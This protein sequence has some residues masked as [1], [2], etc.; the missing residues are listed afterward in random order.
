[1]NELEN[2]YLKQHEPIRSCYLALRE[3]ILA[4]DNYITNEWKYGSSFFYYKGKMFCYLWY[5]KK[6]KQPY[7]AFV[8]GNRFDEPFLIQENRARMKIMLLDPNQDLPIN[9][10]N[11]ILKQALD[12]YRNGAI[13]TPKK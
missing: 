8:E 1:M 9:D 12:L 6:L 11:S 4:Q 2:F 3:I 13:K 7:L 10:L 5:H